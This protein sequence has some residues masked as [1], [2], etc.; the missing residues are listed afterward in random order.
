M[1]QDD[2]WADPTYTSNSAKKHDEQQRQQAMLLNIPP[3]SIEHYLPMPLPNTT[4]SQPPINDFAP[5]YDYTLPDL[6]AFSVADDLWTEPDSSLTPLP[7]PDS[8]YND[9]TPESYLD[10]TEQFALAFHTLLSDDVD[11]PT[12]SHDVRTCFLRDK[13]TTEGTNITLSSLELLDIEAEL[14]ALELAEEQWEEDKRDSRQESR[15]GQR[16]QSEGWMGSCSILYIDWTNEEQAQ[17]EALERLGYAHLPMSDATRAF[18]IQAARTSSLTCRQERAYTEQ[19]FKARKTL[20]TL[21]DNETWDEQR[22]VLQAE[23][24]QI[25]QILICKMQW[26]GI[27]KAPRFLGHGLELDDLIQYAMLGVI[28]GVRAFDPTRNTRLLVAVNWHVFAWLN[29][30]LA[31]YS[32]IIVLPAYMHELLMKIKNRV[33][34]LKL[35]LGRLPTH[36]ELALTEQISVQRIEELLQLDKRV[37]SLQRFAARE[38]QH[39]GYSFQPVEPLLTLQEENIFQIE[40]ASIKQDIDVLLAILS[41]RERYVLSSRY[42]LNDNFGGIRTLEEIGQELKV[43]R[44]RVR[45]I[46]WRAFLKIH[47]KLGLEAPKHKLHHNREGGSRHGTDLSKTLRGEKEELMNVQT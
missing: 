9:A 20:I 16:G 38:Y 28:Q 6:P 4:I 30:A 3:I 40:Q 12:S 43:T 35:A 15:R 37:G 26:A 34:I 46:E 32:R 25:E 7:Q 18:V 14:L 2:L 11:M 41:P 21:S 45:Q 42:D 29:R 23:I 19:L 13:E 10:S 33:Q 22:S 5:I 44:E 47:R 24:S 31:N 1:V 36:E 17:Q 27:K 39:D 8:L